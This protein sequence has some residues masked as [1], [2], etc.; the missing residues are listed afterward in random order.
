VKWKR[1]F[2]LG[3]PRKKRGGGVLAGL[4]QFDPSWIQRGWDLSKMTP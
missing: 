2:I 3:L 4:F 1:R